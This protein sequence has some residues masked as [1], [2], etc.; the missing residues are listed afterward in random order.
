MNGK[1]A[2]DWGWASAVFPADKLEEETEK[3]AHRIALTDPVL[4]M[5]QK[6]TINRQ[7]ELM[8]FKTGMAWSQDVHGRQRVAEGG[9]EEGEGVLEDLPGE[10]TAGRRRLARR[11]LRHR[12]P[13]EVDVLTGI[14]TSDRLWACASAS[15]VG[16]TEAGMRSDSRAGTS[17]RPEIEGGGLK[18]G[19][20]RGGMVQA[21]R[22]LFLV[23]FDIDGTLEVGDP[24]GP[25]TLE[26][27]RY[28]QQSRPPDRKLL[29]SD[30]RRA[31]GDVELQWDRSRFRESQ[32]IGSTHYAPSLI[33]ELRPHRRHHH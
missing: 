1:Q 22:P 6:R 11:P 8:G 4:L 7:M 16:S 30:P 10:R 15:G 9:T 28:V 29:R 25:I 3:L 20:V 27:V 21:E 23:S 24:P 32:D 31:E 33:A 5:M 19:E 12:L 26:L 18:D 14:T 2:Y 13:G 17:D